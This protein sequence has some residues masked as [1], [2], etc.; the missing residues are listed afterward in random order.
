MT[1]KKNN[2]TSL[3][4]LESQADVT[5]V[6]RD[7]LKRAEAG[8]VRA[9]AVATQMRNR[10]TASAY[11]LGDGDIANLVCSLERLKLRLLADGDKED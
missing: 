8:E 1:N 11:A 4:S 6:L 2:L 3:P 7:A 9:V 10:Y 5:G